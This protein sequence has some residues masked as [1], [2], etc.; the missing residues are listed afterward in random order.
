MKKEN[1]NTNNWLVSHLVLKNQDALIRYNEFLSKNRDLMFVDFD[2]T[3][4]SWKIEKEK[5]D[6]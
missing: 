2:Q 5:I 4:Y 6:K 3:Y 1:P